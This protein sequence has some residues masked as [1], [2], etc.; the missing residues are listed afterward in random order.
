MCVKVPMRNASKVNASTYWVDAELGS[1]T[2]GNG[3]SSHHGARFDMRLTRLTENS[4]A[5]IPA[6]RIYLGPGRYARRDKDRLSA[7]DDCGSCV[8]QT[9]S[10]K[11][12]LALELVVI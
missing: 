3:T 2:S 5:G 8:V 12:S 11:L 7:C 4:T 6:A 10:V 1:N 9:K